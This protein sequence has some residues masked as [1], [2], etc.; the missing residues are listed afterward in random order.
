MDI[1]VTVNQFVMTTVHIL[2]S[3]IT[4]FEM[5]SSPYRDVLIPTLCDCPT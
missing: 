2:T 3:A 4:V 5:D 1:F